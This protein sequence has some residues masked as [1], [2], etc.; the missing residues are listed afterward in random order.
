MSVEG[1]VTIIPEETIDF[2]VKSV[3]K[4]KIGMLVGGALGF[5][6]GAMTSTL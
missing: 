6:V 3:K 4:T 1:I 5:A 2:A